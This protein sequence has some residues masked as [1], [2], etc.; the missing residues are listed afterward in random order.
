[1][2]KSF[3]D[4]A[5]TP[6][7]CPTSETHESLFGWRILTTLLSKIERGGVIGQGG[8]TPFDPTIAPLIMAIAERWTIRANCIFLH[9]ERV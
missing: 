8:A 6:N 3:L 5:S 4:A 7:R 9:P 2:G 1:M